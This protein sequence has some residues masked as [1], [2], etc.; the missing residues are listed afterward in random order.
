MKDGSYNIT[1]VHKSQETNKV[2][3]CGTNGRHTVCCFVNLATQ[4]PSGTPSQRIESIKSNIRTFITK[5]GAPS[6]FVESGDSAD[7]YVTASGSQGHVGIYKF[8]Q[9]RTGPTTHNKEQHY[10]GLVLSRRRD[11]PL[12]DKVYA[13]YK[14]KN[15]DTDMLSRRWLPFVS[16]VCMADKGGPKNN[17]Q[18]KWT[19]Q[20]N[21]RLVCGNANQRQY[22]SDLV[23]VATVHAER[24]QDTRVYALFT[25]EWGMSAVCVYT[26]GDIDHIFMTSPFEGSSSAD[27]VNRPRK[28]IEDSTKTDPKT[29]LMIEDSSDMKDWIQPVHKSGPLLLNHHIYTHIYADGSQSKQNGHHTVLFLSLNN[30][31]IHKVIMTE[32][33]SVVIAEYHPFRHKDHVLNMILHPS[34]KKLYVSSRSEL[35]QLN[36]ANCAK[37]GNSCEDCVLARDPFCGWNGTHCTPDTHDTLQNVSTGNHSICQDQPKKGYSSTNTHKDKNMVMVTVPYHSK[38]FLQCPVLSNHAKYSWRHGN[39]FESCKNKGEKCLHLIDS[40]SAEQQG[41]YTCESE[42]LGHRKVLA[43]YQLVLGNRAAGQFS[44]SLLWVCL[45]TALV[46]SMI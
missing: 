36:V 6:A 15:R 26:I 20:M 39:R 16:Q 40:M 14:E 35:V 11:D 3:V 42:E 38:Y 25:N 8:G 43:Q 2:F 45:I 21:A 18:F 27:T 7:L 24:W 32:D 28:C 10:V 9:S 29:I 12:Q 1:V 19:S 37:Y 30:G 22:F 23:D 13:F 34:S 5:D 17:L 31:G 41:M 4:S 33:Q 46:K 44:S